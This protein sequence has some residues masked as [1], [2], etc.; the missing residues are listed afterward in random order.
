M[1]LALMTQRLH[2]EYRSWR[3]PTRQRADIFVPALLCPIKFKELAPYLPSGMIPDPAG[4]SFL[5][6][7]MIAPSGQILTQA[8]QPLQRPLTCR[9]AL[10]RNNAFCRQMATHAPQMP[11]TSGLIEIMR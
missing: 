7:G 2:R 5:G 4:F 6:S 9:A 8:L 3:I 1:L 11:H 10:K